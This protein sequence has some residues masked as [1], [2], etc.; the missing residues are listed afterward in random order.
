M[1][2]ACCVSFFSTGTDFVTD[3]IIFYMVPSV[4]HQRLIL[5]FAFWFLLTCLVSLTCFLVFFLVFFLGSMRACLEFL[6]LFFGYL[7]ACWFPFKVS[8]VL[9]WFNFF[10][11]SWFFICFCI[12]VFF[13]CLLISL[14]G[15]F[16]CVCLF[17]SFLP[18]FLICFCIF[19]FFLG[20]M[21]ACVHSLFPCVLLFLLS[22]LVLTCFLVSLVL[23]VLVCFILNF[24]A[25]LF[26][27]FFLI[28]LV[29]TSFFFP[30]FHAYL[31][32]SFS[33]SLLACFGLETRV[34]KIY[35]FLIL[36]SFKKIYKNF[37]NLCKFF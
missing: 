34:L 17:S 3:D 5:I 8:C 25:C 26:W 13:I 7:H 10:I 1:L 24:L 19:V 37:K 16:L 15:F 32:V 28:C 12:F 20:S 29:L 30:W 9:A 33:G 22:C 2:S 4:F 18:W 35:E 36:K 31:C 14:Q 6:H 11:S 21:H 27:F 23:C